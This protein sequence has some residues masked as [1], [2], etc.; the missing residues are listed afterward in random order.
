M[1][2]HEDVFPTNRHALYEL[3]GYSAAIPQ[4]DLLTIS[5]NWV[6]LRC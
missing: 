5:M 6:A 4:G 2:H 1:Q 3:H